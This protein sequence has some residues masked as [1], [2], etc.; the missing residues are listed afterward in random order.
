MT[1]DMPFSEVKKE[2]SLDDLLAIG[3][4]RSSDDTVSKYSL[5]R[6]RRDGYLNWL[7]TSQQLLG[8]AEIDDPDDKV[9][10]IS[11][12]GDA[13]GE[14][15]STGIDKLKLPVGG[16]QAKGLFGRMKDYVV[17]TFKKGAVNI[18]EGRRRRKY[19]A[20]FGAMGAGAVIGLI[21]GTVV[22]PVVGTA[23]GGAIGA[24]VAAVGAVTAG[25]TLAT[26]GAGIGGF[27]G[28]R[29]AKKRIPRGASYYKVTEDSTKEL[30][31]IA[32]LNDVEITKLSA[33]MKNRKNQYAKN[34]IF[35]KSLDDLIA[36]AFQQGKPHATE[37]AVN[38]MIFFLVDEL[39]TLDGLIQSNSP[40][41]DVSQLTADRMFVQ[42]I[43]D[44]LKEGEF[45]DE[46]AKAY[47]DE[48]AI[49]M[50]EQPKIIKIEDDFKTAV[51]RASD[52]DGVVK[53]LDQYKKAYEALQSK[54]QPSVNIEQVKKSLARA[55]EIIDQR[56]LYQERIDA[57]RATLEQLGKDPSKADERL[58]LLEEINENEAKLNDQCTEAIKGEKVL[59]PLEK[60][61]VLMYKF[62]NIVDTARDIYDQKL[63]KEMEQSCQN[64]I[65][66]VEQRQEQQAKQQQQAQPD[67][68]VQSEPEQSSRRKR[69]PRR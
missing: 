28:R 5:R 37:R 54:K 16:T 9:D 26:I 48:N 13:I 68:E 4:P 39:N 36:R 18:K 17:N 46:K 42:G 45:V 58:A 23:V 63:M 7:Q 51:F 62:M 8:E 3:A 53:A 52:I 50:E 55:Q 49:A 25:I 15:G 57:K 27:F 2:V 34:S 44:R 14:V 12:V 56:A 29:A 47:I 38:Q 41:D 11:M 22:F 33:Y 59:E 30:K 64:E 1:E 20:I 40:K 32:G 61:T 66:A 10:Y 21:I 24:S 43:L 60:S 67:Q 65:Q 69:G 6:L 31:D 35:R 19:A